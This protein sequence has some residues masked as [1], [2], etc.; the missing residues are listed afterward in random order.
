MTDLRASLERL[1]PEPELAPDWADVRRRA[2]RPRRAPAGGPRAAAALARGT[3]A[4]AEPLGGGFS[5]LR[6]RR[7]ARALTRGGDSADR[8]LRLHRQPRR[9]PRPRRRR[10]VRARRGRG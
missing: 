1:V 5:G 9:T 7:R 6:A 2:S 8:E 4:L 3:T 10:D